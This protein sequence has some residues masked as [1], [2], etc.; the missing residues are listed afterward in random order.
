MSNINI[1]PFME[2]SIVPVEEGELPSYA[3][4]PPDYF[5]VTDGK[6]EDWAADEK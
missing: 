3:E 6:G 4:M 2:V 5:Q 1:N